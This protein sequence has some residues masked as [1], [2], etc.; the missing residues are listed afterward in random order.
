MM[1]LLKIFTSLSIS[2]FIGIAIEAHC[3]T[4]SVSESKTNEQF[5]F[6][7]F[8]I[9]KT[10]SNPKG[11]IHLVSKK[12]VDGKIKQLNKIVPAQETGKLLVSLKNSSGR[13]ISQT[14]IYNPLEEELEY[15]GE[16][17]KIGRVT[18]QKSEADFSVRLPYSTDCTSVSVKL[19]GE[20]EQH[21]SISSRLNTD[22]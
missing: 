6:L 2:L 16:N 18:I 17:G 1:R 8:H 20:A 7:N 12:V 21:I 4:L 22:K 13:I 10:P 5:V 14:E 3:Q 19:Y 15:P 11:E 9:S